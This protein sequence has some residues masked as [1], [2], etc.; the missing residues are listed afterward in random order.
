[1]AEE[2]MKV[3]I[4]NLSKELDIKAKDLVAA[5]SKCGIEKNVSGVLSEEEFNI[6]LESLSMEKQTT[7][8]NAYIDGKIGLMPSEKEL[9]AI[10]REEEEK[11]RIEKER[12]EAEE[13][14]KAEE[15]RL[16]A[17]KKKREQEAAQKAA[18]EKKKIQEQE[19]NAQAKKKLD[20]FNERVKKAENT[21][22][23]NKTQDKSR[24]DKNQQVKKPANY[25]APKRQEGGSEEM[26][27]VKR[28][29]RIVDTRGSYVDLSKYD[30][31][32]YDYN[33]NENFHRKSK[34]PP[35]NNRKN[36]K[37]GF[38]FNK[39][40]CKI[41]TGI[42]NSVRLSFLDNVLNLDI[43]ENHYEFECECNVGALF[44]QTKHSANFHWCR[45]VMTNTHI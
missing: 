13:K 22:A 5:L 35:V 28:D 34:K 18:A 20:R 15:A 16:L 26:V 44:F 30:D 2:L 21:P 42:L 12:L 24:E 10:K 43:N 45:F 3:K 32:H 29:V 33:D 7:D 37:K 9:A 40:I 41:K 6:L 39:N 8:I 11:Q 1:M 27:E 36:N 14:A 19:K 17:E 38:T 23:K 4:N 31:K 25:T